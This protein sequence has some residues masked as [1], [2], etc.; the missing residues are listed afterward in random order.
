M[1][2]METVIVLSS[3]VVPVYRST[4]RERGGVEKREGGKGQREGGR[5][6]GR[7]GGRE[8]RREGGRMEQREGKEGGMDGRGKTEGKGWREGRD[9]GKEDG[10]QPALQ[11]YLMK[12]C[13]LTRGVHRT[14]TPRG[15]ST[16]YSAA[17][18]DVTSP[19]SLP[20]ASNKCYRVCIS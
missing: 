2:C 3:R 20:I 14:H 9:G 6:G 16:G 18:I 8:G 10:G 19:G 1:E 5:E 7:G 4:I 17:T 15:T 13:I 11:D 12:P